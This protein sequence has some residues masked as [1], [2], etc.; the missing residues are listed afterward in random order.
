VL[1]GHR[2]PAYSPSPQFEASPA[3]NRAAAPPASPAYEAVLGGV[4]F[5][6]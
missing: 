5:T 2:R 6:R 1:I 3:T 4:Q